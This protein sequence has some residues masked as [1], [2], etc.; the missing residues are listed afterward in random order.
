MK[1][2]QNKYATVQN[3]WQ[4]S[5]HSNKNHSLWK[6][7]LWCNKMKKSSS[8]ALWSNNEENKD[9]GILFL[10][11]CKSKETAEAL[12]DLCTR[13]GLKII[14]FTEFGMMIGVGSGC[15]MFAIILWYKY[16]YTC[17]YLCTIVPL[18]SKRCVWSVL[19]NGHARLK[20]P[21]FIVSS[22]LHS[23]ST[24]PSAADA[25][26]YGNLKDRTKKR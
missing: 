26:H 3:N 18:F 2:T 5:E 22:M 16:K 23:E 25:L 4:D 13:T 21:F 20:T 9:S 6:I 24:C 11:N 15:G 8:V 19:Q 12:A 7:E 17:T 1:T 14:T 10:D